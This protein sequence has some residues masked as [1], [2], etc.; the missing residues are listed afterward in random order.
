MVW[1]LCTSG[2]AVIKAGTNANSTIIV[3]GQALKE[4]SEESES[5]I[6]SVANVDVVTGFSG[7]TTNGKL[8]LQRLC[9]NM[10]GQQIVGYDPAGYTNQR[11]METILD[12]LENQIRQD[13][14]L[15]K[16]DKLKTYLG[17]T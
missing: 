2:Q 4:W 16:D 11:E 1:T 14:A 12:V 8:I 3:S 9:S 17:A 6:S 13:K 7:Y 5:V 10:I 15:I